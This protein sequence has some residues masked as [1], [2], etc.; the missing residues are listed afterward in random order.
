VR[1][2][3]SRTSSSAAGP[4]TRRRRA[5]RGQRSGPA[6]LC[7][8]FVRLGRTQVPVT[9]VEKQP[10]EQRAG[11]RNNGSQ[12]ARVFS[13]ARERADDAG[14]AHLL[15]AASGGSSSYGPLHLTNT[16]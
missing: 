5:E 9:C 6:P 3:G 16:V 12:R 11:L 4:S 13:I 14:I 2:D 1:E 7:L 8:S 15:L 10:A